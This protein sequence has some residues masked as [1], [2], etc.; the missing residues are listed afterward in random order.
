[1][2]PK[3]LDSEIIK[4]EQKTRQ[5]SSAYSIFLFKQE[6][7]KVGSDESTFYENIIKVIISILEKCFSKDD[8]SRLRKCNILEYERD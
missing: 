4:I 6:K 5:I 1:M 8:F 3:L 2:K 7:I